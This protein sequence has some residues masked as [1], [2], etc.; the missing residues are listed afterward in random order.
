MKSKNFSVV[1]DQKDNKSTTF[2]DVLHT[3]CAELGLSQFQLAT[4]I[5]YSEAAISRAVNG[6]RPLSQKMA[7]KLEGK[8]GGAADAW[9]LVYEQTKE[10]GSSLSVSHFRDVLLG[11][12]V[13]E[14]LPGI[15]VR[16]M[17][18]QDIIDIFGNSDGTM[19][20]RGVREECEIHPFDPDAVEETSYDTHV[21][22]YFHE[23][24]SKDK[25]IEEV[26]NEVIIPA[27]ELRM[28]ITR[29]HISLPSWLEADL[30]P[31]WSIGRKGLF[32][33]HGPIIDP[34]KWSGRLHVNVFN[35]TRQDICIS[36][37]E[38]FI[39]LRF[40]MLDNQ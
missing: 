19:E 31:A 2:G 35:P 3:V 38:P 23:G 26:E 11:E 6:S 36:T 25:C 12:E 5:G 15:R 10:Q 7:E 1:G 39:T 32:V 4:L 30:N 13:V 33:A 18:K 29:E 27:G 8:I 28:I 9:M 14:D 21:G 24:R 37:T 16:R 17:R 40:E 34:G 20:F 22:G